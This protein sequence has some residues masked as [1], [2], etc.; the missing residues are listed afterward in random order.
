MLE[1]G[2]KFICLTFASFMHYVATMLVF[3]LPIDIA[4]KVFGVPQFYAIL[5]GVFALWIWSMMTGAAILKTANT[6][7]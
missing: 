3:F 4:H 2:I 5:F 1:R 6:D 7:E